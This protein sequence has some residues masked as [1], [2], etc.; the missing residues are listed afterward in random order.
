MKHRVKHGKKKHSKKH[1]GKL[2]LEPSLKHS[3]KM[4]RKK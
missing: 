3:K 1:G 4:R 2:R